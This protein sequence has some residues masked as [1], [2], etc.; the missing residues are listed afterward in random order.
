MSPFRPPGTLLFA[1]ALG[2][3][4]R[5]WNLEAWDR[6]LPEAREFFEGAVLLQGVKSLPTM[7]PISRP[8]PTPLGLAS[9]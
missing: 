4:M 1:E 5:V 3:A 9:A 2:R 8:I 6:L 7:T